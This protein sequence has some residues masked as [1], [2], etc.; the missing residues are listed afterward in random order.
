MYTKYLN[1]KHKINYFISFAVQNAHQTS[2]IVVTTTGENETK[3]MKQYRLSTCTTVERLD[4]GKYNDDLIKAKT[5]T[6]VYWN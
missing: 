6:Y 3:T 5:I 1:K 2:Y 4:N